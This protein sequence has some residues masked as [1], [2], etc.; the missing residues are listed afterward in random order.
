MRW[1]RTTVRLAIPRSGRCCGPAAT[2]CKTAAKTPRP[3]HPDRD[4]QF[5]YLTPKVNDYLAANDPVISMGTKKKEL[6]G[7]YKNAGREW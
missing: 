7:N 4:A 2:A 6:V 5:R 1:L 3:Q